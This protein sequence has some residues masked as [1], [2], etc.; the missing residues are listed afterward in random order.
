MEFRRCA[1]T[2]PESKSGATTTPLSWLSRERY[3][4]AKSRGFRAQHVERL[5][6]LA[7]CRRPD[8]TP[9]I[10]V[11]VALR[12]EQFNWRWI[13]ADHLVMTVNIATLAGSRV[14]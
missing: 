9:F 7:S 3:D 6:W 1:S 10:L 11:F 5:G 8:E 4:S 2:S 14:S 12:L 13:G